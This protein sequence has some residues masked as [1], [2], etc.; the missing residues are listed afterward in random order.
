MD[1]EAIVAR[2]WPGEDARVEVLGGG[3]TDHNMRIDVAGGSYVLRVGGEI[4]RAHV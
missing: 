2:I 1:V 3:I 4:G